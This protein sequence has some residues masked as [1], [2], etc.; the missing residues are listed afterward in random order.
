MEKYTW[1]YKYRGNYNMPYSTPYNRLPCNLRCTKKFPYRYQC[2][3]VYGEEYPELYYQVYIGKKDARV[4]LLEMKLY[5]EI[6]LDETPIIILGY[7]H[8]FTAE[9]LDSYI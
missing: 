1:S 8:F 9:T 3:S 6:D 5:R 7:G 4:D 2:P